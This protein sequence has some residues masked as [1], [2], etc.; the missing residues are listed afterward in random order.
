LLI[1]EIDLPIRD[2]TAIQPGVSCRIPM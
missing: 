1:Q 2:G